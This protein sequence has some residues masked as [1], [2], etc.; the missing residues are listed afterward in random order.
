MG[1]LDSRWLS[2][3]REATPWSRSG[4][5]CIPERTFGYSHIAA[6]LTNSQKSPPRRNTGRCWRRA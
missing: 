4:V 2:S 6:T 3:N 1:F 5:T